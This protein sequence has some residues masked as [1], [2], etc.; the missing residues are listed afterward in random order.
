MINSKNNFILLGNANTSERRFFFEIDSN[1]IF[2]RKNEIAIND[3]QKSNYENIVEYKNRYYVSGSNY[4][5]ATKN[6]DFM[7]FKL[8]TTG[9]ELWGKKVPV[10]NSNELSGGIV[11]LR[12]GNIGMTFF[13]EL[14]KCDPFTFEAS[15]TYVEI[16]TNGVIKKNIKNTKDKITV[17][18]GLIELDNNNFL[19]CGSAPFYYCLSKTDPNFSKQAYLARVDGQMNVLW[20]KKIGQPSIIPVFRKIIKLQDGAF[21][22]IG[23]TY[24]YNPAN[25]YGRVSGLLLKFDEWGGVVWEKKY[26]IA[27][28]NI[29]NDNFLN[30]AVEMNN[31]DIVACGHIDESELLPA[32]EYAQKGWLLRVDKMGE[33]KENQIIEGQK[34][35]I[36]IY[37]NPFDHQLTIKHPLEAKKAKLF[38]L[39]GQ[40]LKEIILKKEETVVEIDKNLSSGNYYL[41]LEDH[42]GNVIE[43][44]KIIKK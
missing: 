36:E 29:R 27:Y 3:K 20:E 25:G 35:Q 2:K 6:L 19:I 1:F 31:G 38:T 24:D 5:E 9:K 30:D 23:T 10:A 14:Y 39:M 21:L 4:V 43:K 32:G 16:D 22:A 33:I 12:N 34:S 13:S 26:Q 18:K 8:D 40:Q 28:D 42:N 44:K 15:F 17:S 37:P 7:Y 11:A 41:L